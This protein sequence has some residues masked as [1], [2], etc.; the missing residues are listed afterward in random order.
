M[1]RRVGWAQPGA[2]VGDV[3]LVRGSL[4]GSTRGAP[5]LSALFAGHVV[6]AKG[7]LDVA[8]LAIGYRVQ[9]TWVL[10]RPA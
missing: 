8:L 4:G 2:E 10:R 1:D 7:V 9:R 5:A 6:W 3:A